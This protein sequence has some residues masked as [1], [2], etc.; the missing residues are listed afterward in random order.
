MKGA[1]AFTISMIL[2]IGL[3]DL[4]Y[5]YIVSKNIKVNYGKHKNFEYAFFND[6]IYFTIS[7][8]FLLVFY[9]LYNENFFELIL[10]KVP[11]YKEILD[12]G[13]FTGLALVLVGILIKIFYHGCLQIIHYK[14][15]LMN[16][17]ESE[18]TWI[19]IVGSFLLSVVGFKN[20]DFMFAFS[21]LT[22]IVAYFF[23]VINNDLKSI[24]DKIQKLKS[25]P[26]Y[27]IIFIIVVWAVSLVSLF[28]PKYQEQIV[29]GIIIGLFIGIIM[30]AFLYKKNNISK[31]E[32]SEMGME[33]KFRAWDKN[34]QIM[35]EIRDLYWFNEKGVHNSDK[36]KGNINYILMTYSGLNDSKRT[37]ELPEGQEVYEG[38]IIMDLNGDIY[39]VTFL[40]GKFI[41]DAK[42]GIIGRKDLELVISEKAYVV[43]NIYEKDTLKF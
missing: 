14:I 36:E 40:N 17:E 32:W 38:D 35:E 19:M 7:S 8:L 9:E 13:L 31:E 11:H 1:I 15:N 26:I 3:S 2:G 16:L 6:M 23:W 41:A 33:L 27:T 4:V 25:L 24:K 10:D 34:K 43:G 37:N 39:K 5:K 18:Q 28:F 12:S 22:L 42:S 20:G 30:C 29:F 21:A